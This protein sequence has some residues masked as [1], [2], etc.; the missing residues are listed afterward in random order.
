VVSWA[1]VA[2][3]YADLHCDSVGPVLPVALAFVNKC[4]EKLYK[5][6]P[7]LLAFPQNPVKA[8]WPLVGIP[9]VPAGTNPADAPA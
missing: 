5:P 2:L 3:E 6:F 8:S 4:V 7:A 9:D 1:Q